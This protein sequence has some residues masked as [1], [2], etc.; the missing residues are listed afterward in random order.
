MTNITTKDYFGQQGVQEKFKQLLGAKAQGFITSVLQI[1]SSNNLLAKADPQSVYNAAATAA[2]LDLPINN[3]LGYAY[4][5]PY[6]GQAQF[7]IGWKGFVQLAQRTGQYK[8]INVVSVY[9]NQFKSFNSLTEE[10]DADFTKLGEGEPIGYAAFFRL[11]NG[12]EKIVYWT[13]A[14]IDVHA[15]KYSQA[16]RSGGQSPWKDKDQFHDMAKKTVLKNAL[17]KWGI[18]SIEMQT[19]VTNDQAVIKSDGTV[20][21]VDNPELATDGQKDYLESLI[22]TSAFSHDEQ[23]MMIETMRSE[24]FTSPEYD[25]MLVN[26]QNNQLDRVASGMNYSQTDIKNKLNAEVK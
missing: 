3:N 20:E 24:E 11:A 6:K 8:Q 22:K 18:L 15:N 9:Q 10:L 19:A 2:V 12:F 1:V 5:L 17:S 26:V 13:K 23:D 21:Y 16:M 14:Q 7:Q 25:A 4:I